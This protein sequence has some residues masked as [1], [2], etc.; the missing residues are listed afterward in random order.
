MNDCMELYQDDKSVFSIS[1][2]GFS[3][4]IP[5]SYKF[6]VYKWKGFSAWGVGLWLEKWNR[7]G[8][9]IG[10]E[11]TK[12]VI[13]KNKKALNR[14]SEH[15]VPQIL[16][17]TANNRKTAD[18]L[19][20][21]YMITHDL[22]TIFPV[23]SRVKNIGHDGTGEHSGITNKYLEQP[24]DDMAIY[25]LFKD[26]SPNKEIDRELKIHFKISKYHKAKILIASILPSRLKKSL[27]RK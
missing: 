18:S 15:L 11:K 22:F 3:V 4:N 26:V 10:I 14:V 1:G 7:A 2:Y 12:E 16:F 19:I 25:Q 6:D 17:D 13:L 21:V 9:D 23:I 27:F 24:I 5:K 8:W 20:S